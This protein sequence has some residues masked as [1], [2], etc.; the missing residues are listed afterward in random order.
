MS[1]EEGEGGVAID[2]VCGRPVLEEDAEH[3]EYQRRTYHF[4]SPGCRARFERQA[5]RLHVSDLARRGA[6]FGERKARWGVA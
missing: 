6:L 2:P 5:Q 4:C 3:L 1:A